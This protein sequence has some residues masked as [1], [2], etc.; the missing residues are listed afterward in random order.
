MF[1]SILSEINV[2]AESFFSFDQKHE[3]RKITREKVNQNYENLLAEEEA[4][5]NDAPIEVK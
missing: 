4:M 3:P 2:N 5:N 1:E